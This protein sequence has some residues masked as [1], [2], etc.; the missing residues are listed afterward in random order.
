MLR[1]ALLFLSKQSWLQG[2][3]AKSPVTRTVVKRF[4][5]GET[6]DAGIAVA[7]ALRDDGILTTL[8]HLGEHVTRIEEAE[9]SL[10]AGLQALERLKQ[11]DL[12]GTLSI[13]LSQF[14]LDISGQ[15]CRRLVAA[16]VER[17]RA[18]GMR[19]EID[20]ESSASTDKTLS[21]VREM[22][23]RYGNI[24]AVVQ[25][26]LYRTVADVE[27]LCSEGVPV[28]L[29]KGAYSELPSVAFPHKKDVDGNYRK[30]VELLLEKGVEPAFATHDPAMILA[31]LGGI[32]R[33]RLAPDAFEFQM[34]YGVRRDL[35]RDLV[36]R[37]YRVRLYVPYGAAWYPYFVRRL[38]ERPANV[39]F[40]L[41][42]LFR[43]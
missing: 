10:D 3:L 33:R 8:D 22:H 19:I 32:E 37:G 24:R 29:C 17:A 15:E 2:P 12:G 38:A 21:V 41:K 30:L 28:R 5:A 34:L 26:Y 20:M 43:H 18:A 6:L 31:A 4:V 36:K 39:L 42:A 7:R 11:E 40:L 23:A 1:S 27:A 35:Q 16:L 14:G 25:A 13:K 9:E